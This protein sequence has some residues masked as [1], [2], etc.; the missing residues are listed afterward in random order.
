MAVAL[1]GIRVARLHVARLNRVR[2]SLLAAFRTS[3]GPPRPAGHSRELVLGRLLL[4]PALDP[5]LDVVVLA[6]LTALDLLHLLHRE[7][8]TAE[9]KE[10]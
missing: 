1:W 5:L 8:G 7:W 4:V 2:C 3:P 6:P 9:Q 10:H